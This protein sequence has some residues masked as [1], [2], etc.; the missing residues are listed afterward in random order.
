MDLKDAKEA[1][2][3]EL[4]EYAVAK[5]TDDEPDSVWWVHYIFNKLDRIIAKDKTKY[6]RKTHNYGVRLPKTAAEALKLYR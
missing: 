3:I 1:S 4:S 6:W 5:N 2:M